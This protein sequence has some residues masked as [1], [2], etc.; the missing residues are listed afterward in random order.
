MFARRSSVGR[1]LKK[2][3]KSMYEYYSETFLEFNKF[4]VNL[5]KFIID[6]LYYFINLNTKIKIKLL[7]K[8]ALVPIKK[9]YGSAGYDVFS[10]DTFTIKAWKRQLVPTGLST[11]FSKHFYLRIAPHIGISLKGIDI[12]A[13]IIDSGYRGEIKI[14]FINNSDRDQ[15]FKPG[16]KIA[17]F[18]LERCS[19][20][21]ISLS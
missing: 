8:D 12:G 2:E 10:I 5:G 19:D 3:V 16:D 15:T 13:G 9:Y 20:A 17:Q 1:T 6:K 7:N 14:L 18:I 11:K 21:E 4:I